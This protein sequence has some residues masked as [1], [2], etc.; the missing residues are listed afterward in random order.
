MSAPM[1]TNRIVWLLCFG[2]SS[3]LTGAG[4]PVWVDDLSARLKC[5]MTVQEVQAQTSLKLVSLEGAHPWLGTY[6]FRKNDTDLWIQLEEGKLKS[7]VVSRP[8]GLKTVLLS[9]KRNLCA[10]TVSFWLRIYLPEELADSRV[11]LDGASVPQSEKLLAEIELPEGEHEVR[12]EQ[13]GYEP[14]LRHF[15]NGPKDPGEIKVRI[16]PSEL[17]RISQS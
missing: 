17:R 4:T 10:G 15:K 6:Y 5:G 2:L 7:L 1:K 12:I 16:T 8:K 3:C 11:L 9:P 14:V 13:G